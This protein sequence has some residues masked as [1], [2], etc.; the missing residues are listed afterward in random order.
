MTRTTTDKPAPTNTSR[1]IVRQSWKGWMV[2]DRERKGPAL[3]GT[4]W[5]VD[6]T[7][8]QAER[9]ARLLAAGEARLDA[10]D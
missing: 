1:F 5:A 7:Q 9:T 8:E 3:V 4:N 6:L 2:Y 10:K